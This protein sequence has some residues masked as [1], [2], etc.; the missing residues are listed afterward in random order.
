MAYDERLADRV[1]AALDD[2]PDVTEIKMFGGLCFTVRGNMA[3][4]VSGD[5]LMVR[6]APDDAEAALS[7]DGTRPMEMTGRPMKGI[8]LVGPEAVGTV[9]RLDRWVDRGVGFAS[10][11]PPKSPKAQNARSKA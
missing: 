4:G 6:M 1:R 5:D 10:S 3:I 7:E 2:V 8:V 9:R 11:L